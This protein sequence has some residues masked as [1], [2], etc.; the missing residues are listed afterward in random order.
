MKLCN[1]DWTE[2]DE[3]CVFSSVTHPHPC[4]SY[5]HCSPPLIHKG[6]IAWRVFHK[7]MNSN[8]AIHKVTASLVTSCP[9]QNSKKYCQGQPSDTVPYSQ[10]HGFL[11]E[12][13]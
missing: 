12:L 11:A 6:Q 4:C 10:L 1:E 5:F 13:L 7:D 2:I 9:L 3:D 8:S